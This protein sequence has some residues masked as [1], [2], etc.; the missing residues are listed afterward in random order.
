[1]L[2]DYHTHSFYSFDG[3]APLE[4]MAIAACKLGLRE[5]CCTDHLDFDMLVHHIP[6]FTARQEEIC[7]LKQQYPDLILR[8]GAEVS[9]RDVDCARSAS[10]VLS[11]ADLDF[12]LGSLH[13]IDGIN[14]W[15][16]PYYAGKTKQEAYR[17][18]LE[19]AAGILPTF[20]QMNVLAHYD[21]VAKYAPYPDRTMTLED[22]PDAFD[23]IFRWLIAGG[24]GL[25]INTASWQAD[26]SWGQDIL[27]RY[28]ELGGE[29]VT[30]GSDTHGTERLGARIPEAQELAK[31]AGIP[32]VATFCRGA[33][34]FH[35]I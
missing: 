32:W 29:Y 11:G 19:A 33:P 6:D 15:D 12:I 25:E 8:R 1:M 13:T 3:E 27:R 7:R 16:A 14:V 28:R 31:Q 30:L 2:L 22:A 20:P 18:Y 4:Q 10:A 9:L 24:R 34:E 26:A 23:T 5:I 21:F 17:L 35:R